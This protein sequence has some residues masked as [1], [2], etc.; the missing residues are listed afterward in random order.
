MELEL[1]LKETVIYVNEKKGIWMKVE[2]HFCLTDS[3]KLS[4]N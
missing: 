3:D 2:I 1:E 4:D